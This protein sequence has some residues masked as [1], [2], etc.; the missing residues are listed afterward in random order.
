MLFG[1]GRLDAARFAASLPL[2]N[3]PGTRWN[4]NSAGEILVSDALTRAVL[5]NPAS[6]EDRRALMLDWMHASLFDPI[7][8]RS[9]QPG[10]DPT[11]LFIGSSFVYASAKDFARFGLLYLRDG[12]WDGRRVLPEGWV[13]FA[14][15]PAPA[16][17]VDIYGAGW[18]INPATGNGRPFPAYIDTG[19]RRD[20][21]RAEGHDGQIILLVPSRD[22]I[23]VRLGL[24][25]DWAALYDW[26]GRIARAL[27]APRP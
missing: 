16:A 2:A 5:P 3:E 18:W 26:M 25:K 9:V 20:A 10:F 21:F 12:M 4:Y 13:D 23:V 24:S 6:P 7:G 19:P 11:G 1:A 17:N 15:T 27:P 8:M 22:L 14:R